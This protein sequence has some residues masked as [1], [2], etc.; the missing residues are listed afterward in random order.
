M[1]QA[2]IDHGAKL[3]ITDKDGCTALHLLCSGVRIPIENL[4]YIERRLEMQKKNLS[5]TGSE[6]FAKAYRE[7]VA[8]AQAEVESGQALLEDYFRTAKAL[9]DYGMDPGEKDNYGNTALDYAVKSEAKK[10]A[11]LLKGEYDETNPDSVIAGGMTLHQAAG[12]G[13]IEALK[14]IIANGANINEISDSD[15]EEFKGLAPLAIACIKVDPETVQTLLDA[16]ADPNFKAGEHGYTALYNMIHKASFNV[17]GETYKTKKIQRI[18]KS[19]V[20]AG[21]NLDDTIDDLSNTAFIESCRILSRARINGDSFDAT[22]IATFM[23]LGCDVNL[24]NKD[25]Q[26]ALMLM[27]KKDLDTENLFITLLENGAKTDAVDSHGNTPL[28]YAAGN[29]NQSAAKTYIEIMAEFGDLKAGAVN[30]KG[31]TAM[32]IA[33]DK[34]YEAVVKQLIAI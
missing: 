34:N 22:L 11:A 17:N 30:N 7:A 31:K 29:D 10:I 2:M 13:D 3:S 9:L 15:N 33:V 32:E 24:S 8:E 5:E 26:T 28:M 18:L 19:L 4:P 16:G 27:A 14:A 23:E 25:G 20:A 6:N 1:I 12:K 21:L